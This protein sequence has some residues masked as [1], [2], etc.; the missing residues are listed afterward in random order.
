MLFGV[1]FFFWFFLNKHL[2]KPT[3]PSGTLNSSDVDLR[4]TGD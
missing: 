2:L 4:I 3:M 1:F